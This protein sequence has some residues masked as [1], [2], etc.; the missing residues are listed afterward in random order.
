M[1]PFQN[2]EVAA[3]FEACPSRLRGKLL[4]LRTL[5]LETAESTEGVGEIEEALKWGEPAYLTPQTG[6]GST[7]RIA[8]KESAPQEYA[9]CFHCQTNLI[10]TF[11]GRF[12][13]LTFDGNRRIVFGESDPLPV[14]A[15]SS[16]IAAAL[17]YHRDKRARRR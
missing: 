12:P 13:G 14:E 7:V 3:V 16:C 1:K 6:S 4:A 15:L 8:W 10:E 5:I 17:T 2:P 9:L 11:R